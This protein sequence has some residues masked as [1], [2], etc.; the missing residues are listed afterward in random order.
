V[1]FGSRHISFNQLIDLAEGRMAPDLQGQARTHTAAC[2]HC[3]SQLAWL[4]RVMGIMRANDYEEPPDRVAAGITR[5]F[6][7]YRPAAASLRRRVMAVLH[8]DSAQLPMSVGRR[9]GIST[10]RQLLFSAAALDLEV[11][12]TPA[13]AL[14]EVS[15]QVLNADARGLVELQGPA[16]AAQAS[17]NEAGEFLLPLL[18]PGQY[19]L[20]LQLTTAEAEIVIDGLAIGA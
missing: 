15:G 20:L 7:S 13:G 6:E 18:P 16:G 9:A 4:E 12:I 5:A 2:S 3:A 1:S 14:W 8:F 19:S 10:E 17:L 11:R